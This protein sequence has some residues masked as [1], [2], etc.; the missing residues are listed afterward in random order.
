MSLVFFIAYLIHRM[1]YNKK[2]KF[3]YIQ[4]ENDLTV[5]HIRAPLSKRIDSVRFTLMGKGIKSRRIRYTL[6]F[7]NKYTAE[8]AYDYVAGSENYLESSQLTFRL[9]GKRIKITSPYKWIYI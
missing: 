5:W 4:D 6:F 8:R 1:I 2:P 7:K 9:R 3:M